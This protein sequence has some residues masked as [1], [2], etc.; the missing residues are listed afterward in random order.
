MQIGRVFSFPTLEFEEMR[1][2]LLQKPW[3]RLA[4]AGIVTSGIVA[5]IYG[6]VT[7]ANPSQHVENAAEADQPL[8]ALQ[9]TAYRS[10]TCGCCGSWVQHLRD[11]GFQV[12]DRVTDEMD[13]IKQQHQVPSDL[14]SCHTA[15]INGY[16]VE[17]HIPATDIRRLL[18]EK[19]NAIGIAVPGMPIGSPGME[20]GNIRQPY[21]TF[22]FR[23]D[24][25]VESFQ[26]HPS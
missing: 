26:K 22:L 3:F 6:I 2:K 23:S 15:V 19:P 9:L 21:T 24:G 16:V 11:E 8:K 10:P 18:R 5:G 12:T 25:T 13:A 7:F 4:A 17:G 1:P 20:S 14:V